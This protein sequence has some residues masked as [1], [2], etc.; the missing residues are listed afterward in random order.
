MRLVQG[1][2]STLNQLARDLYAPGLCT[3]DTNTAENF[4]QDNYTPSACNIDAKY[5][6]THCKKFRANSKLAED[7]RAR[8]GGMANGYLNQPKATAEVDCN[9]MVPHRADMGSYRDI[10]ARSVLFHAK[11]LKKYCKIIFQ[12]GRK[13]ISP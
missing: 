10:H 3:N 7:P 9:G 4:A 8:P 1:Y 11:G 2:G 6:T 13:K 5:N 12:N